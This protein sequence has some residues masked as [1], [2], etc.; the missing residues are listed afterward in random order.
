MQSTIET[1][2]FLA[3]NDVRALIL[4]HEVMYAARLAM[5]LSTNK[6][7]MGDFD[8]ETGQ[9]L[10]NAIDEVYGKWFL[11]GEP[12]LWNMAIERRMPQLQRIITKKGAYFIH[13]LKYAEASD[14]ENRFS[15]FEF[16]R[17]VARGIWA[18][19]NSELIYYTNA[20]DE[21]FSIQAEKDILRNLLV[22]LAEIPLGYPAY[23]SGA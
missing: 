13:E 15:V 1:R 17:E 4:K 14:P 5:H 6:F 21:R 18:N 3:S 23:A 19:L 16:R 12:F 7:V 8:M 2:K 20:N 9:D 22:H 10:E 11:G